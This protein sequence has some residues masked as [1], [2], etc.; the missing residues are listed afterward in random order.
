[1]LGVEYAPHLHVQALENIRS[2]RHSSQRS[3][4][5]ESMA[6]NAAEFDFPDGDLVVFLFN[7]FGPEVTRLM[8]ANLQRSLERNPRHVLMLMMWP[9]HGDVVAQTPGVRTVTRNA[10][11]H[12]Y[13]VEPLPAVMPLTS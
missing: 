1:V 11:Y 2:F 5:I 3:G 13:E 6:A 10:R 8:L 9:E 12:V 7:P 4:P